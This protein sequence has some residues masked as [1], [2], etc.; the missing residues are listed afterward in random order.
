MSDFQDWTP[1]VL[2]KKPGTTASSNNKEGYKALSRMTHEEAKARKLERDDEDV[3]VEEKSSV[4]FRKA[5]QQARLAKGMSQ[6]DLA[7]AL[8]VK[9]NVVNDWEA[10][11]E[12]PSSNMVVKLNRVLG[13]RLG[14][15]V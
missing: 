8:T 12:K 3:V 7:R 10:G 9:K 5:L 4:E 14:K 2:G 11:R 6:E 1:V 13:V 15:V